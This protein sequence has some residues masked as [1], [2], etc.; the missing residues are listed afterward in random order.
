MADVKRVG[1][2]EGELLYPAYDLVVFLY[3]AHPTHGVVDNRP[4]LRVQRLAR[5]AFEEIRG[6]RVAAMENF[7]RIINGHG[8][9]GTHKNLPGPGCCLFRRTV[10]A[11][12]QLVDLRPKASEAERWLERL[13]AIGQ[14]NFDELV[15]KKAILF[16]GA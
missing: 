14:E 3:R 12:D 6:G 15:A 9:N 11:Q 16:A 8:R 5:F 2:H 10:H 1:F 4:E 13:Y 7:E